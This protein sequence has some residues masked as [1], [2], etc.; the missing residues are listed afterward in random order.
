MYDRNSKWRRRKTPLNQQ[1]MQTG[2]FLSDKNEKKTRKYN[3]QNGF[4]KNTTKNSA[5]PEHTP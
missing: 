5:K 2:I 3:Y 1:R 4:R